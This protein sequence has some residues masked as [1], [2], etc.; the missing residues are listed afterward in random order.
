[1]LEFRFDTQLCGNYVQLFCQVDIYCRF[2]S[3]FLIVSK[4][5][6]CSNRFV[7]FFSC[8]QDQSVFTLQ[9]LCNFRKKFSIF[10]Y[11]FAAFYS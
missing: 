11:V 1:M 2:S 5:C 6:C 4:T 8:R 3:Y 7:I 10:F 9:C